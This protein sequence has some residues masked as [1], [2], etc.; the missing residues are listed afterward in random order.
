MR[1]GCQA[2]LAKIPPKYP[3]GGGNEWGNLGFRIFDFGLGKR[4]GRD[5]WGWRMWHGVQEMA[6]VRSFNAIIFIV[7]LINYPSNPQH[8]LIALPD[9]QSK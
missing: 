4:E 5:E 6:G 8:E 2:S 3:M 1:D 7:F 9:S